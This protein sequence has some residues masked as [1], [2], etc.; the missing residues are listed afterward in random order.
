M[1]TGYVNNNLEPVVKISLLNENNEITDIFAM[2]DTCFNGDICLSENLIDKMNLS[3]Y[4]YEYFELANG[5]LELNEVF[6]GQIVFVS[7]SE[8]T[9][10]GTSLLRDRTLFVDFINKRVIIDIVR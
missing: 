1:I 8:D 10:I 7:S 3:F 4:A 5:E 9:L 6:E 2:I